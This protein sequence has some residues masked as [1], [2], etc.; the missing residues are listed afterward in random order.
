VGAGAV[1]APINPIP[2]GQTASYTLARQLS[3]YTSLDQFPEFLAATKTVVMYI[4]PNNNVFHLN[5]PLAGMEGVQLGEQLQGEQHVPFEQILLESA[6]LTGAVVQRTNI[7]KRE[8]NLRVQIGGPGMN[9]YTYRLAEQRWWAG[10]VES[11]P[12]WLGVFT[13]FSGWRWI[14]VW[15]YKTVDTAQQR[16]PVAYGNN[17]AVW[18]VNWLAPYPLWAKPAVFKQWT[19]NTS[20]AAHSDGFYYGNLVLAN[21][22]DMDVRIQ[23]LI[24][25]AGFCKLQD[26]GADDKMVTLPQIFASDGAVL[27]NTD[28]AQ[29]TLTAENDPVDNIFYQTARN[30]GILNFFLTGAGS[31][32]EAIWKRGYVR[33]MNTTPPQSVTHF[34]V[35]HTNPNATITAIL[36]QYFRR[37]R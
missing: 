26:N 37:S 24:T 4:D 12:G 3:S 17:F 32:G 30:S 33:F 34:T 18:D 23:Y 15:P 10:Q 7:N 19:A 35:A 36:P 6:F 1:T 20:G 28:P 31:A 14:Q 13:R 29:R 9:N 11:Q 5:G 21:R 16:D 27:C 22:G 8:I 2:I 25:G